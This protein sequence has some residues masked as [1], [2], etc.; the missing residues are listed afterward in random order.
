MHVRDREIREKKNEREHYVHSY[1]NIISQ[2][3]QCIKPI[4]ERVIRKIN[5]GKF[6]VPPSAYV[7]D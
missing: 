5:R 7:G 1:D 4:S 6:T 3:F 2:S